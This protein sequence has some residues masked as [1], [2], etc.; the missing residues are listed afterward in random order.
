MSEEAS[1][2]TEP[3]CLVSMDCV[4]VGG[5]RL[6]EVFTPD[7]I[8]LAE[9]F[10]NQAVERRIRAFLRA[11]LDDHLAELNLWETVSRDR[12]IQT[13]GAEDLPPDLP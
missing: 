4:E 6:F 12:H 7:T 3:V 1:D 13:L 9:S 2:V 10:A 8:E 11:T 5:V